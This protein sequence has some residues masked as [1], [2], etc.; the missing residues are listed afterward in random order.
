M[1]GFV[2]ADGHTTILAQLEDP[3]LGRQFLADIRAIDSEIIMDKSK[4]DA[5]SKL[6]ALLQSG[7]FILQCIARFQQHLP[8][9][10]LEVAT[11]AFAA[12]NVVMWILWF[13]KPLAVQFP[14]PIGQTF[15]KTSLAMGNCEGN[16]PAK[17]PSRIFTSIVTAIYGSVND[18]NR[19]SSAV[20]M[21]WSPSMD[22][23]FSHAFY[24]EVSVAI[25][26][27]AIHCAAWNASF[28]SVAE[29]WLWRSSSLVIIV[30]PALM[31]IVQVR[32]PQGFP[33][34]TLVEVSFM[35]TMLVY[36]VSRL[37]LIVLPFTTLRRIPAG[38][39]SDVDWSSDIPHF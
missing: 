37:L 32:G 6:V 29:K 20:P 39:L 25:V 21:L 15:P 16:E 36:V 13:H 9:T 22:A 14:I 11:V 35:G 17:K 3:V 30:I 26:F 7:W 4:G 5:L 12:V 33:K 34:S 31:G 1:G 18:N 2:S 8:I 19:A 28:P 23:T 38:A 27:G 10:E 24:L